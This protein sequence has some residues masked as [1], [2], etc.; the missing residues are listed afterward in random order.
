M[1]R[2]RV[3]VIGV[4]ALGRHHAR[5]LSEMNHVELVAV[6]D[7]QSER[8]NEVAT[9]HNTR[10][11]ADYREL[12]DRSKVDAVSVVVPT[13][14]HRTVAGAF[15]EKGI[16]VL[17][18]KPLAANLQEAKELLYL[19]S[20]HQTLLQVGHIERFNPAFQAAKPLIRAPKYIRC[21]LLYTSPSPRDRG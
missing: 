16:P 11:V 5:I 12:L 14:A 18:E 21:C 13:V 19:A 4:G 2:L 9:K 20:Q 8:G 17:V 15:L 6:A 1:N 7:S 10:W 3:A